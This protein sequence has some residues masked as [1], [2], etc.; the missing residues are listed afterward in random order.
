MQASSERITIL[1]VEDEP[2]IL[3]LLATTLRSHGYNLLTASSGSEALSLVDGFHG[4]IALVLT[5]AM[6]PG[7]TGIELAQTLRTTHPA[8]PVMMMSGYAD[9][10][11]EAEADG[12]SISVLQ[13]PFTPTEL[14]ARVR[15]ILGRIGSERGS[16]RG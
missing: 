13:K 4:P 1:I 2:S 16:E 15:E 14:R 8:V 10:L 12:L 5:D 7:M 9:I 11:D 3:H 6:M